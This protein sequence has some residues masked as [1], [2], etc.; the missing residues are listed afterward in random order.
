MR[1]I[2]H[3]LYSVNAKVKG[4]LKM[5][6]LE[7]KNLTQ[8]DESRIVENGQV[9]LVR[10][11][12]VTFTQLTL[13][14]GWQWSRSVQPLVKTH[15]CQVHHVGHVISGWMVVR[16]DNGEEI[17][18]GPGDVYDIPPGHDAWIVGDETYVGVDV[19]GE[20]SHFAQS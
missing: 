3:V 1:K 11:G 16:L 2:L 10:V 17:E 13:Q 15:S 4:L 8:P 19:S 5:S 18:Y 7:K 6:S 9:D 14:P 12:G 20:M